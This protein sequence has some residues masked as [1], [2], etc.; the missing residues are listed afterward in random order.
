MALALGTNCGFVKMAP[1]ADPS[2][3]AFTIDDV[4]SV[5]KH[6]SPTNATKI[7]E[8]GWWCDTATEE[9]NFEVGLYAANG[10]VV[11]GEAGTLLH[12]SRTNAKGTTSGWKRVAVDWPIT[13]NT[14][15]WIGLQVDNTAS[16]T[17]SDW[18]N[19]NGAGIDNLG[20][21]KTTLPDP[22][23]GGALIDADA[24]DA[25]Y[26]VY[27][28]DLTTAVGSFDVSGQNILLIATRL[29]NATVGAFSMTGIN[30]ILTVARTIIAGVGT[31]VLTGIDAALSWHTLRLFTTPKPVTSFINT[32]K[33][34]FGETWKTWDVAWKDE[35]RTW[36][37]LASWIDNTSKVSANITNIS[38]P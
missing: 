7:V 22:C 10:A 23:G 19:I 38:K 25:F 17:S 9:A 33:V 8:V 34:N 27:T 14:V 15:Y 24:M 28:A 29:L 26:A 4:A 5:T 37:E 13:P 18:S 12:V 20:S 32:D 6:T 11:P 3:S 30:T 35:T 21:G 2:G 36:D 1:T 31:F 16:P